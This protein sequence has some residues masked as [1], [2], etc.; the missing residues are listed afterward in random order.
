MFSST[1]NNKI[2]EKLKKFK[3][4]SRNSKKNSEFSDPFWHFKKF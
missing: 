1:F 4:N 2:Q 3:E